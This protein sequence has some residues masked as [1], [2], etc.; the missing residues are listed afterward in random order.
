MNTVIDYLFSAAS[1]LPHGVCLAWRPDMVALHAVSDLLIAAA[2]FSIPLAILAFMRQRKDIQFRG[3]YLLFAAFIFAC[4]TTHLLGVYT[5]WNPLYGLEGLVKVATALVSLATAAM[6]WPMLPKA[7]ALPSPAMLRKSNAQL[8][9]EI[10]RREGIEGELRET[11]TRIEREV[12]ARTAEL[13]EAVQ[14]LTREI[15]ER[16]RIEAQLRART[17]ELEAIL[18]TVPVGVWITHDNRASTIV[19]NRYAAEMLRLPHDA[20]LSKTA[21]VAERPTH[22]RVLKNGVEIASDDLPMQRA[23]RGEDIRNEELQVMFDDG[24]WIYE[25]VSAT[26]VRDA[27]GKVTGAVAAAVDI[28]S[29]K[30]HEQRQQILMREVNH[31]AKNVM[32]VVHS[33]AHQSFDQSTD[34]ARTFGGRIAALAHA[35]DML[36]ANQWAGGGLREIAESAFAPYL[37][38]AGQPRAEIVGPDVLLTSDAAQTLSLILH[39]ISVNAAKHGAWS[40]T[41]GRVSLA[42]RLEDERLV[43]DWAETGGPPVRQPLRK[44]FGMSLVKRAPQHGLQGSSDV[45]FRVDGLRV[46]IALPKT[47]VRTGTAGAGKDPL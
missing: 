31:R 46:T 34:A 10:V 8:S 15:T 1:F 36:A 21:G 16:K 42:W 23:A 5:L 3:V 14:L 30:L 7:L 24:D 40:N 44:G 18:E 33:I 28:T 25:L 45:E 11:N 35:H 20:N 12:A 2:Y 32:A 39:E 38:P 41:Q 19:G 43:I 13:S 4:G 37:G 9:A 29:R 26:P 6:L 27:D 22:F 47:H 17:A